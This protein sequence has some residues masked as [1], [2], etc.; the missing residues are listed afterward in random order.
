MGIGISGAGKKEGHGTL[1][2]H[3]A[4]VESCDIY[5]YQVGLKVGVDRIAH[6]ANEFGLGRPTGIALP[7]EKTGIVPSTSWKKKRLG[8]HGIVEKPSL[9]P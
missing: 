4:I 5:F 7:H 1:N 6:Y 8:F 9:L 3:R 2:L